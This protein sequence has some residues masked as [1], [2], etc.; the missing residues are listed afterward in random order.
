MSFWKI[1]W[2]N[3]QQRALA[4]TLTA[5]S[6]ALGVALMILVL[7]IHGVVVNQLTNDAQGYHVIVGGGKGSKFEV[8]LSTVFHLGTPL[9]PVSYSYYEKFV[10][11]GEYAP[12]TE[13]AIPICLGDSYEANDGT[14]LRVVATTPDMFSKISYAADKQYEFAEGE[15][16]QRENYYEAVLGSVAAYKTGLGVGDKF[17]PA[18]GISSDQG[19]HDK[20]TVVGVL[21]PTGTANDRAMFINM[22]GFYLQEGHALSAKTAVQ[23]PVV[24]GSK[25]ASGSGLNVGD[26]LPS[27]AEGEAR[28]SVL[29][30]LGPTGTSNDQLVFAP[31]EG[32][33]LP[34]TA[35]STTEKPLPLAAD[36]TKPLPRAQREVTSILVLCKSPFYAGEIDRQINKGID[37]TVQV[38]APRGVVAQLADGFLAPMRMI[39]LVLTIM[40]VVVAGISILV[41]IYNSMSERSHDIAV[42]RAL[43]AKRSAVMLIVLFESVLLALLG[44]IAG[45]LLGHG[46]LAVAS[47]IVERYTGVMVAPWQTSPEEWLLVPGLLVFAALVGFL[48]ALTAYRTDVAKTLSGGR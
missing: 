43:G 7:V 44:G 33:E 41:S 5:F 35:T 26:K 19:D 31:S 37:R 34:K 42:M 9:Y 14:R 6:M 1:A 15:N 46:I 23:R 10:D 29:A 22:E 45:M 40:I 48:P 11:G 20:F 30:V 4:S 24:L 39:L 38:V 13:A 8:V 28:S 18:H 12:Y 36:G 21:A 25:V 3:L 2:R 47:P 32:Y 16:F 17:R 27:K